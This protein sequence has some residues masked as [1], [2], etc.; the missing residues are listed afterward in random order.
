M[1]SSLTRDPLLKQRGAQARQAGRS[2]PARG[3]RRT[4]NP[5]NRL[6]PRQQLERA[7]ERSECLIRVVP[8]PAAIRPSPISSLAPLHIQLI[9]PDS[10][11][12]ATG[13]ASPIAPRPGPGGRREGHRRSRRH[14]HM[15][16]LRAAR[17]QRT[18]PQLLNQLIARPRP[19]SLRSSSKAST[20]RGMRPPGASSRPLLLRPLAKDPGSRKRIRLSDGTD[21]CSF[22]AE[23]S[24][25]ERHPPRLHG[26]GRGVYRIASRLQP[27]CGSQCSHKTRHEVSHASP[28][29]PHRRT[30][31]HRRSRTEAAGMGPP[32]WPPA[33]HS[34]AQRRCPTLASLPSPRAA[35]PVSDAPPVL[36]RD[37]AA[38]VIAARPCHPQPEAPAWLQVLA[39]RTV[40][41]PKEASNAQVPLSSRTADGAFAAGE[42]PLTIRGAAYR[43]ADRAGSGLGRSASRSRRVRPPRRLTSAAPSSSTSR[44]SIRT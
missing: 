20:A 16:L 21:R 28:A 30:R 29:Q 37:P 14:V 13:G 44:T 22:A 8:Q 11:Q 40:L 7:A 31:A 33:T 39:C 26:P 17:R 36:R 34:A 10:Q 41:A 9:G 12:I 1:Q 19:R 4:R 38:P 43:P 18:R 23:P 35:T 27:V 42:S 3:A 6:P 32:S 24:A 5:D 2:R 15:H 25:A